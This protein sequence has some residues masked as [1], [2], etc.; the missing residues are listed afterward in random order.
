MNMS[1]EKIIGNSY[2][3][4]DANLKVTGQLKYVGDMKLP[5]MLYGKMLLSP[6][7]HANIKSIDISEA[8]K[9]PG[10]RAIATCFNTPQ[11]KYNSALRFYEHDI[12]NTEVIFPQT[13]RFVGDRVAAVA[14]E[15]EKAAKEAIKL[16]KVEYEELLV[17]FDVEE[18]IKEEAIHIHSGGNKVIEMRADAGDVD[19]AF[20]EC[21]RI[22]EDRY[23]VPPIHHGAIET[24]VAIA[25]YDYTDKL[26]LWAPT[27]NTFAFRILLS[28]IM[29]IPLH[30]VRVIRP[31]IGGAFGGKLEMT[32]E[33]VE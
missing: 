2:P 33:P 5:N 18:A 6:V 7:A 25:Q 19:K 14:A 31:T 4:K 24:H 12:P 21:D 26:T 16:I 9:V 3:V 8:L 27:Q 15:T 22:F 30:K 20:K 29:N 28:Q 1:K 10:V 17:I 32:I 23:E 11:T 13:V